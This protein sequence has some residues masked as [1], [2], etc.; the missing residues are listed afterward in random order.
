M[1]YELDFSALAWKE[2]QKLNS[3]V[4]EQFKAKLRKRLENPK[5]S[6]DKLSGQKDCYKIKLRNSGYRLVYQV[7][8]D[9]VVV[10]VISVGKRERS[11]AYKAAQ[12][13]LR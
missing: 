2:W 5:V 11:E 3:T 8:D 4:R 10:F 9:V 12:K 7:L 13:R 6:K 1:T